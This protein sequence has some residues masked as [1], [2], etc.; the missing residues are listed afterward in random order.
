MDR[1][2]ARRLGY[3]ALLAG[4]VGLYVFICLLP[5]SAQ[6][7]RI[8]GPDLVTTLIFAWVLRRPDYVPV[9]L[10]AGLIFLADMLFQRPPGLRTALTLLGV[11]FLRARGALNRDMPF[12]VEW[13]SVGVVMLAILL[14][15]RLVLGLFVVEQASFGRSLLQVVT[16]VVFYPLVVLASVALFGVRRV[17]PG[18]AEG[19][20]GGTT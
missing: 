8:P 1:I 19:L 4:L 17:L 12:A 6:A 2:M 18:E 5:L 16:S 11:E 15:E 9:L 7:A 20:R 14:G 3:Q 13:L 10:V